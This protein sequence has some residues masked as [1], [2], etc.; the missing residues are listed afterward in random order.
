M[1]IGDKKLLHNVAFPENEKKKEDQFVEVEVIEEKEVPNIFGDG[2]GIGYKA[3]GTDGNYYLC[4]WDAFPDDSTTPTWMWYRDI[5]KEEISKAIDGDYAV[6]YDVTQGLYID[7]EPIWLPKF[8][9]VIG[10][11]KQHLGL[12][13]KS[14]GCF[15][16]NH[17]PDYEPYRKPQNWIGWK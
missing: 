3:K 14:D 5:P 2:T 7:F 10:F 12:Y 15:W 11:C 17:L 8:S 1:K 9:H 13:N 16:C 6:W 4:N